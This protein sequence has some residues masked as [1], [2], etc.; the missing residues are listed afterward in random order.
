MECSG[1][2]VVS[3]P[4]HVKDFNETL[5]DTWPTVKCSGPYSEKWPTKGVK[6]GDTLQALLE[7][8]ALY[9]IESWN[10]PKDF[11]KPVKAISLPQDVPSTSDCRLIEL[12]NQVQRLMEAHLAPKKPIQVNK[13]TSSCEIYSGPHDTQYCMEN[14][15]QAFVD[16]ASS[17]TDDRRLSSLRAQLRRQQDHVINKINILWRVFSKKLDD[18]S[19]RDTVGNSMAHMDVASI[20]QIRKEE[21]QTKGIKS[22]SKLLSLKYLSQASLE[23]QNRNPSSPKHFHF[24]NFVVILRKEDEVREEENVKP[25]ATKYNDHEMTAKAKEKVE[26][27]SKDEFEDKIKDKEEEDVEYFDTFPTLEDLGYHEWILKYPK[28][29]WVKAKIRTG[30]LNNV[31]FSCMIG[32]FVKKQAYIDFESPVNVMSR[33]HYNWIMSDTTSVIDH[34]LGAVVFGK[35]FVE[36]TGLIYDKKEGTIAFGEDNKRLIF[37]MPHK[38]KM[39]Q[40]VDFMRVSTDRIPPFVIEGDDDGNE[41]THYSD[42]LN[43]GPEYKYDERVC[44][45]IQSLMRMKNMRKNKGEV[46]FRRLCRKMLLKNMPRLCD[47]TFVFVVLALGWLLVEIHVTWAHLEKKRTRLRLYTKSLE[48]IRIQIVETALGFHATSSGFAS[49]GVRCLAMASER[50]KPK[51]TLEDSASQDKEDYST[52]A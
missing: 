33:L 42:S 39:F 17:H 38:M 21:L 52:C 49:D 23:E 8:L 24:I 45:A 28:P 26:E 1:S 18:T 37:K 46:T 47:S 6:S 34:D 50:S 43:L 16:Y 3:I 48:E 22:P 19:T 15:E 12:E 20:D 30:S 41:K 14:P 7:D 11:A 4:D 5:Y 36:K 51:Q 9:D 32:H 35:P 31:K 25:N 29:S 13:I 2:V 10:D 40:N 27:E 44:K